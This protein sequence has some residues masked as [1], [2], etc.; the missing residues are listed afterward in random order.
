MPSLSKV[1][2]LAKV[3]ETVCQILIR[4]LSEK[5]QF[6]R[7]KYLKIPLGLTEKECLAKEQISRDKTCCSNKI[8][9]MI[10]K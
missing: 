9:Q 7:M 4:Q 2:N 8:L 10:E 1:Q 3:L 5:A 6:L